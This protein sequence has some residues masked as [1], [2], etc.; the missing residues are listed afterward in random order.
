MAKQTS[1]ILGGFV[2]QLGPA[3][4]YMWRGIYCVRSKPTRVRNPRTPQQQAHRL[5]FRTEV[6]LASRMKQALRRGL[7]EASREDGMLPQNLFMQLN[8]QYFS[9]EEK[10][11]AEATA[12]IY[13]RQNEMYAN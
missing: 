13:N 2:G 7:Q 11:G 8:R 1:G 4:G 12:T 6:Q 3:I 5:L 9:L 10:T